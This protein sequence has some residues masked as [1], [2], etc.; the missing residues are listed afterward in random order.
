MRF[1]VSIH[2]LLQKL[3]GTMCVIAQRFAN[4]DETITNRVNW[5]IWPIKK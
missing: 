2:F 3:G 4:I 5:P 1:F